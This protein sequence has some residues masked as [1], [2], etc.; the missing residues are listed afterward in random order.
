MS[1]GPPATPPVVKNLMIAIG[2]VY[3]LQVVTQ[4]AYSG[5]F[6]VVP[7]LV[8]QQGWIWQ[9]FT[10]MWLHASLMHIVFNMFALWMFGSTLALHWGE[11]RFLR[12][13]LTCGF[14]AGFVI[15]IRLVGEWF[16]A[17]QVGMAQGIYGGWGNFGSAAAAMTLPTV[18][19][20][21]GGDDGWRY[22]IASTGVLAFFYGFFFYLKAKK[23]THIVQHVLQSKRNVLQ[24]QFSG[25][26]L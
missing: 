12:Y 8:W 25:L 24:F 4:N 5:L 1:F 26:H 6:V 10:Y 7:G 13:Y 11:Q 22:A 18:A 15:G 3:V 14:G 2:V 16:P 21:F 9:P 23:I 17:Q 19:L 20:L